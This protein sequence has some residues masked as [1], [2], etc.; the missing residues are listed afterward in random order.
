MLLKSP[1]DTKVVRG[2]N[3]AA[4]HRAGNV[5]SAFKFEKSWCF[6]T[7]CEELIKA[8][9]KLRQIDTTPK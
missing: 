5:I 6:S 4:L 3:K 8:F 7:V 9:P 1:D 2:H